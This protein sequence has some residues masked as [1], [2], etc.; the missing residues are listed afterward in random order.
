M[1]DQTGCILVMYNIFKEHI[2]CFIL[3]H[4]RTNLSFIGSLSPKAA[5]KRNRSVSLAF[6]WKEFTIK[7]ADKINTK[8]IYFLELSI[9]V[10]FLLWHSFIWTKTIK[11]SNFQVWNGRQTH[12]KKNTPLYAS[13]FVLYTLLSHN[14]HS[15]VS[16]V[17][18][19][20]LLNVSVFHLTHYCRN[21]KL[22][23]D[24][25]VCIMRQ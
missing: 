25:L 21:L 16:T 7:G 13:V 9:T 11:R 23:L 18:S 1:W 12:Q 14:S 3:S 19:F 2:P 17:F 5:G 8:Y 4:W 22:S 15:E 20:M 24:P 6:I 10:F